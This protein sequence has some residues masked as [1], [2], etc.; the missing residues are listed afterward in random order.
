MGSKALKE[1]Q[2]SVW[3]LKE[4]TYESASTSKIT[5]SFKQVD[6]YNYIT[7]KTV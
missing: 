1:K 4:Y 5:T 3:G 2:A 7:D 6:S